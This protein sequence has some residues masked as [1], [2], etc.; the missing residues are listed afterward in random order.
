MDYGAS[1]CSLP[2][3]LSD[4]ARAAVWQRSDE[5]WSFDVVCPDCVGQ[6]AGLAR[7]EWRGLA[8]CRGVAG[9]KSPYQLV[10]ITDAQYYD[11]VSFVHAS[12]IHSA[13]VRP[14]GDAA[15]VAATTGQDV[16]NVGADGRVTS[17]QIRRRSAADG[18]SKRSLY[19]KNV[20]VAASSKRMQAPALSSIRRHHR[21]FERRD[22]VVATDGVIAWIWRLARHVVTHA[23]LRSV[24][25]DWATNDVRYRYALP[26]FSLI[27]PLICQTGRIAVEV[28]IAR[29]IDK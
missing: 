5:V 4:F 24:S 14:V 8:I 28:E 27:A 10:I 11:H 2:A 7:R 17:A 25:S 1:W 12:A 22:C 21:S 29:N 23:P 26:S 15:V 20:G 13:D 9:A 18:I 6:Q 19:R 3:Q 16:L